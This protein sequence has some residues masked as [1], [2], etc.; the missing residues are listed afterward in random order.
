MRF[1]ALGKRCAFLAVGGLEACCLNVEAI[2]AQP[3]PN[4]AEPSLSVTLGLVRKE[5]GTMEYVIVFAVAAMFALYTL[6]I[7]RLLEN[8]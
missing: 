8:A 3:K 2:F 5:N 7:R 1:A 4:R 6:I